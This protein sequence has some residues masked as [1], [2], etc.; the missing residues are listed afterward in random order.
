MEQ[1]AKPSKGDRSFVR[2]PF[3]DCG[4]QTKAVLAAWHPVKMPGFS[5]R[6]RTRTQ[7]M[8]VAEAL[9]VTHAT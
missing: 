5:V 4:A 7:A 1:I 3:R 6:Q 9:T 2:R 8:T